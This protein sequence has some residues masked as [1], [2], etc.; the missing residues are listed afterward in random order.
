MPR[1]SP[2][3]PLAVNF[4]RVPEQ[5][6]QHLPQMTAVD[7]HAGRH[8]LV[9]VQ[10]ESNLLLHQ[11]I[12]EHLLEVGGHPA[13]VGRR[14]VVVDA[15]GFD[16]RQV[17]DVVDQ[18]EQVRAT[19][20][21][22]TERLALRRRQVA[23]ALQQLRVAEHAVQRSA[24]LVAHVR[25]E[26]ALGLCRRLGG[27]L[28]LPQFRLVTPPLR[29]VAQERTEKRPA[30]RSNR[31]GHRDFDGKLVAVPVQRREL[32]PAVQNRAFAGRQE[33]G[34][35]ARMRVAQ[36]GRDDQFGERLADGLFA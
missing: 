2:I 9:D 33:P 15:A 11:L 31:V 21:D 5:I 35:P 8:R 6:E 3:S 36:A 28:R 10:R 24:E 32:E 25:Q 22:R 12:G 1:R 13:Q 7:E 20:G 30:V 27:V 26:L 34:E 23:V 4:D 29:D 18:I 16:A 19:G 17:E 14:G